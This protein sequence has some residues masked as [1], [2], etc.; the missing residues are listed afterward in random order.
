MSVYKNNGRWYCRGNIKGKRYNYACKNCNTKSEAKRFEQ[1]LLYELENKKEEP[2]I[3]TLKF[4]MDRYVQVC[5]ANN[6]T[7]DKARTQRKL[8]CTYFGTD[9]NVLEIKPSDIERFKAYMLSSGRSKATTNRYLAGI[10]RAYNIL[11]ADDLINYNPMRKVS[12]YSENNRRYRYLNKQEWERLKEVLPE[13]LYYIVSVALLT[14]LRKSN[15]LKLKW[16]QIDFNL[17]LIEILKQDNKGNKRI[18]KPITDA[19]YELLLALKPKSKGYIFPNPD[20][21]KPYTSVR[22][23][24]NTALKKA[25]IEDFRFHDLRR[26]VGTWLLQNGVDIRVIQSLLDHSDVRVTERYLAITPEQNVRAMTY[27]DYF[28]KN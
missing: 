12:L 1:E 16:E 10:R 4:M 26:T 22:K 5:E 28:L 19:L 15:V 11:L 9:R 21:G 27:L 20:T 6:K 7:P 14:G 24:F 23:S 18:Y 3:I 25:G 13:N 2:D 8:I 17:R